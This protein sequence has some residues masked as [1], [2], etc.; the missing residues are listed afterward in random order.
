MKKIMTNYINLKNLAKASV[1]SIAALWSCEDP[2]Y[3]TAV[4]NP[5]PSGFSANFLF[6]NVA[7]G[8][9]SL[10]MHINNSKTGASAD[11]GT[12]QSGYT[13]VTI[14]S[15]G[16]GGFTANTNIRAKATSGTI[17]GVLGSNDVIYRAG[18]NNTNNFAAVNGA[19]YSLFAL[20]SISRPR[21]AR[22]LNAQ[23]F[24]DTTFFNPSSG[25]YISVVQ[26]AALSPAQRA[27][28][29]PIGIVPLGASDPGGVRFYLVRDIYPTFAAG[30]TTQSGI[31]LVQASPR[32][33]TDGLWVRLNPVSTGSII[34]LGANVPYILGFPA[35]SPTVGSRTVTGTGVNFTLQ[36]TNIA[37]V[38]NQ[39]RVEVA[40]DA[41]FTNIIH[42]SEPVQFLV[43]KVY[44]VVIRGIEGGTGNRALGATVVQHN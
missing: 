1:F 6:V 8:S 31:R 43:D 18:N 34:S 17:G 36:N 11:F 38:P 26:K 21:P 28:L 2:E 9:P 23:N 25:G 42:T 39:Y 37:S 32:N 3:I 20:D 24:G 33:T 29:V 41:A 12:G 35:F 10:D 13:T 4:P 30:N 22:T 15:G 19:R 40:K 44:T 7:P 14:T 27:K 16:A 5:Q